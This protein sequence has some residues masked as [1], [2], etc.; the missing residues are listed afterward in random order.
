M[1]ATEDPNL[2]LED[3]GGDEALNWVR[4]RNA[5]SLAELQGTPGYA[6]LE[7]RLRAI[8]DSKDRI[9]GVYKI[10]E[11]YY[12]FWQD[13]EHPQGIWRRTTLESYRSEETE[14]ETVLDLDALGKAEDE[15]WVWKGSSVLE[16]A[17]DLAMISLSRGG[18]DATVKREFNLETKQFVDG[19]FTLP[20]AKSY[21]SWLDRDTLWVGTD[22]GEGSQTESGYPRIVKKW[23]RGTPIEEAEQTF[24]IDA[25]ELGLFIGHQVTQGR[26]YDM[27]TRAM[28]FYTNKAYLLHEGEWVEINKP[29]DVSMGVFGD[30]LTFQPREDWTVDGE[31]FLAG[32]LLTA[33]VDAFLAGDRDLKVVFAPAERTSLDGVSATKNYLLLNV[34]DNVRSRPYA[35]KFVGEAWELMPLDAPEFGRVS[36]RGLD[37]DESDDYF[38]TVEDFLTPTSLYHAVVGEPGKQ[39]LRTLP[40][41]FDASGLKIEQREAVS[42]DGTRVPYF[43]IGPEDLKLDGTNPTL[44]YGYGGF[45]VSMDPFYSGS[46]GTA[47]LEKGGVYVLANIRGGGEF[48]PKWHRAALK[49]NRQRAYDD[50]AAVAEDLIQRKVTSRE[51]LG[52]QGG[53]NGGLLMGVMLTQRPDLFSAVL[54]QV[55]LLDMKRYHLLLAGASWM[56]EYGDPDKPEEW[57]F[58]SKYSPYQNVKEGVDYPRTLFTTSTRDDR[59]HPGHARKMMARMESHGYDVLYYE[60][61]EGGHGGAANNEQR[62][63][64]NALGYTFLWNEVK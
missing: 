60:N 17:E 59:V 40:A 21:V 28:T 58:I 56:G 41:F 2:W 33:K 12:N 16:P 13:A 20:E 39:L 6:E 64:M 47:W 54:C 51:H 24:E 62:A 48:G 61:I 44:L 3:V 5:V 4:E 1:S 49:A 31:T 45:E 32:S 42:A 11:L 36:L 35:A 29:D 34:L 30:W 9:P 18:A 10:G 26:H 14:W 55:P 52:T 7:A 19:G 38:M 53:S 57:E 46:I 22:F 27:I 43:Q 25:E 15:N 37:S 50:F 63:R 8:Y 23:R